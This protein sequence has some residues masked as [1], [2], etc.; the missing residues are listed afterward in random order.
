M[1]TQ[2]R[3]ACSSSLWTSSLKKAKSWH[4]DAAQD[5]T[6]IQMAS[7]QGLRSLAELLLFSNHAIILDRWQARH[8]MNHVNQGTHSSA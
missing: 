4:C 8:S 7:M 5:L 6:L 2:L 3:N 1:L